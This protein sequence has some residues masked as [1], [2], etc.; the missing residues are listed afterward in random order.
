MVAPRN[1]LKPTCLGLN[2]IT[3]QCTVSTPNI[4]CNAFL[5][6]EFRD[7]DKIELLTYSECQHYINCS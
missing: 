6:T 3:Y 7:F 1:I 4:I 2:V 5:G